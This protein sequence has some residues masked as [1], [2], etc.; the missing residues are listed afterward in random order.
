M[1]YEKLEQLIRLLLLMQGR[2]G[3]VGL[4]DIEDEFDVSRRTAERMRDALMRAVPQVSEFTDDSRHL[5][6]RLSMC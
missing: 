4:Q 5:L 1:R 6:W 2:R 3:G